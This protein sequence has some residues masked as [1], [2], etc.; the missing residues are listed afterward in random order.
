MKNIFI[1]A[2]GFFVSLGTQAGD[3]GLL[4]YDPWPFSLDPIPWEKMDGVWVD[5][6]QPQSTVFC[7]QTLKTFKLNQAPKI[8]LKQGQVAVRE[9][10]RKSGGLLLIGVGTQKENQLFGSLLSARGKHPFAMV[11]P[12]QG[13]PAAGKPPGKTSPVERLSLRI[14]TAIGK[15]YVY[16]DTMLKRLGD[17][18]T[19]LFSQFCESN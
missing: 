19:R 5:E 1:L 17:A 14:Y 2:L 3:F 12:R 18:E 4:G 8:V 13:P 10:D 11:A 6:S 9:V 15:D 7:V 16:S